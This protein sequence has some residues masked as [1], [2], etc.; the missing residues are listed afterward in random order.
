MLEPLRLRLAE[1]PYLC[2]ESPAYADYL[3]FA[4]FQW[5]R[6]VEPEDLLGPEETTIRD[7]RSR[8]L[9]RFDGLA[10]SVAAYE[11]AA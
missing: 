2:G 10:R 3:A 7:W 6:C 11:T 1:S 4:E 9:D 5:A 8:L